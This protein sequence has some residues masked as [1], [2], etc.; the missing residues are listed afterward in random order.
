M[1]QTKPSDAP[2][3]PMKV[4]LPAEDVR[5]KRTLGSEA[6]SAGPPL[7]ACTSARTGPPFGPPTPGAPTKSP[8]AKSPAGCT[9]AT[10]TADVTP[11]ER[12]V[13]RGSPHM[14]STR[15]WDGC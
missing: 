7:A 1:T 14:S 5:L 4:A 15:D 11:S 2:A 13:I 8:V 6:G 12:S 3:A 10:L 9:L